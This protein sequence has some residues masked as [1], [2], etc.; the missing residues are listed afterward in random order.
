MYRILVFS[1]VLLTIDF[2]ILE[3]NRA[4][5]NLKTDFLIYVPTLFLLSPNTSSTS[6]PSTFFALHSRPKKEHTFGF[7]F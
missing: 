5:F 6:K 1:F 3:N 4:I 2:R 7:F